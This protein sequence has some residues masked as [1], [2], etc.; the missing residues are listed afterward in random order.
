MTGNTF[1][2]I[3]HFAV[4]AATTVTMAPWRT[5]LPAYLLKFLQPRYNV[6]V[7]VQNIH[8]LFSETRLK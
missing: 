8:E 1:H 5:L 2:A 6:V 7:C 3:I 4:L